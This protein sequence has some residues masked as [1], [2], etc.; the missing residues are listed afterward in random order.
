MAPLHKNVYFFIDN[1][2]ALYALQSNFS[3]DCD[4]V[5]KCLDLI[6]ILEGAGAMVHFIW[7]PSHVGIPL[8]EKAD[9]LAQCGLEDDTVDPG[10]EYT[11][12][13][14]NSFAPDVKKARPS[15]GNLCKL[16]ILVVFVYCAAIF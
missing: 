13:Y 2:A 6:H 14:G 5:N 11:L 8:N 7:I 15:A 1:Q 3:M 16:V 4:L 12:G 10:T 9:R